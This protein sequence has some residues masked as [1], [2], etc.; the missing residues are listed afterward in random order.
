MFRSFL[1]WGIPGP[2]EAR[3]RCSRT[4]R[5]AGE[6]AAR[7]ELGSERIDIVLGARLLDAKGL[8]EALDQVIARRPLG[9]RNPEKP[10]RAI[11]GQVARLTQIERDQLTLDL[12]PVEGSIS[13]P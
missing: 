3:Y 7:V 2:R 13:Q 12:P 10:A 1:P 5:L 4:G 11:D 9:E 8:D 6:E